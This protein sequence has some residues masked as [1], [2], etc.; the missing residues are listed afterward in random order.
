MTKI[1][2]IFWVLSPT[3]HWDKTVFE[4][5]RDMDRCEATIE[6]LEA[7]NPHDDFKLQFAARCVEV[8]K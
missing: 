4:G 5:F 8:P 2:L 1:V 6:A 7:R 3:G